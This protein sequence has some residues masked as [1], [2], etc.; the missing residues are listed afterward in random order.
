[1]TFTITITV[2]ITV[3][4]T[5]AATSVVLYLLLPCA[6]VSSI[7]VPSSANDAV[8]NIVVIRSGSIYDLIVCNLLLLLFLLLPLV[9]FFSELEYLYN[10]ITSCI[11]I[12]NVNFFSYRAIATASIVADIIITIIIIII[13]TTTTMQ[14]NKST[15]TG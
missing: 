8:A 3:A 7:V 12:N 4:V 9:T 13:T 14:F 6:I 2:T 15:I 5:V 11:K 10:P 1:M